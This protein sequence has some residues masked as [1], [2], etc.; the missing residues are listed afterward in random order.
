MNPVPQTVFRPYQGF[1]PVLYNGYTE[2][3]LC[4]V[5]QTIC[6]HDHEDSMNKF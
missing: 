3:K 1:L 6:G 5:F 4:D 2:L